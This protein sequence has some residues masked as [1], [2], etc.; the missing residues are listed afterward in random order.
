MALFFS[1]LIHGMLK[2][3]WMSQ[4]VVEALSRWVFFQNFFFFIG[5]K[6]VVTVLLTLD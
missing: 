1:S 3:D 6:H 4:P 2:D 5:Q